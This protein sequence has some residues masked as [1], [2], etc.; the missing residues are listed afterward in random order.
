M[1]KTLALLTLLALA[2]PLH[3]AVTG[4]QARAAYARLQQLAG[5]WRARSTKGWTEKAT[6][7]LVGK[8]SAVLE[9]SSFIDTPQESM[10]S[11]FHLDGDRLLL[12]HYCE[13]RNQ[14]RLVAT[15]ISADGRSLV[16]S[17]LDGTNLH[18]PLEGHMHGVRLHLIDDDHMT[19]QW[20]FFK[21]GQEQWMEEI[22][23]ERVR[24]GP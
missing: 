9:L 11:M 8:G 23:S 4:E 21:G 24:Q 12:T 20:S 6:Y 14:P 1:K 13:A 22:T 18:P 2:L 19:S 17:F 5:S 3:A 10:A 15:E 7:T 16:F